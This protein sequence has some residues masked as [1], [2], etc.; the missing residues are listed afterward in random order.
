MDKIRSSS[1]AAARDA[2]RVCSHNPLSNA[3]EARARMLVPSA[4]LTLERR[5]ILLNISGGDV[6]ITSLIQNILLF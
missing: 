1:I 4:L 6:A 3:T 5:I 2:G